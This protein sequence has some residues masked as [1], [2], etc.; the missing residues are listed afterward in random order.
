MSGE[1]PPPRIQTSV[2]VLAETP[3]A[4]QDFF[5][6]LL[7]RSITRPLS[8]PLCVADE[9]KHDPATHRRKRTQSAGP[10]NQRNWDLAFG[11]L[12]ADALKKRQ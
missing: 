2:P 8:L 10:P 3:P 4:W 9:P 12:Y 1:A 7:L 5:L 6:S 11:N